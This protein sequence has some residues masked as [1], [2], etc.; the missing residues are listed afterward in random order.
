MDIKEAFAVALKQVR[1]AKRLTQEDFSNVS[2]RTYV[3]TL[4]RGLKNPT[5]DKIEDLANVMEIHPLT[6][7]TF[8][9]MVGRSDLDSVELFSLVTKQLDQLALL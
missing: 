4:E 3:S 9:Y 6:L 1:T 7:I 2:S 5:L 8:A